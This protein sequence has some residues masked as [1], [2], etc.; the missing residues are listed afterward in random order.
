[1]FYPWF[2]ITASSLLYWLKFWTGSF[3]YL[4]SCTLVSIS[5]W[6]SQTAEN[7]VIPL[8]LFLSLNIIAAACQ[9]SFFLYSL[10]FKIGV[11][12]E[13]SQARIQK[14]TWLHVKEC[15]RT[16]TI[17]CS[18]EPRFSRRQNGDESDSEKKKKGGEIK[19]GAKYN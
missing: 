11:G 17:R 12:G 19:R 10:S 8:Q 2:W 14:K 13:N 3:F 7:I 15:Q 6:P 5:I 1:M 4:A 9:N 16:E 18:C